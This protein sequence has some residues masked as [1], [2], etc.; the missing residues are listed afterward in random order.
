[1]L[2]VSVRHS[3]RP[4]WQ[5][6]YDFNIHNDEKRIEKLRYLHRNPVVRVHMIRRQGRN[7]G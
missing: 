7:K 4:F 6:R 2:S 3:E 5:K 1:M